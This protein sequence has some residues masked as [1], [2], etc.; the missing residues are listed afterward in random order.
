MAEILSEKQKLVDRLASLT[1]RAQAIFD[2]AES[3][4]RDLTEAEEKT[5]AELSADAGK[6]RARIDGLEN[7]AAADAWLSTPGERKV[8]DSFR[9]AGPDAR[10]PRGSYANL[11]G[12]PTARHEFRDLADFM[13]AA[14]AGN[15]SRLIRNAMT[16]GGGA[17][18]LLPQQYSQQLLD[19]AFESEIVRPRATVLPM[20]TSE[21]ILPAFNYTDRTGAKRAGLAM[22]IVGEGALN[23]A[24][25]ASVTN[26][27]MTA[28]KGAIFVDVSSELESDTPGFPQYLQVAMSSAIAGG[29]DFY[30]VQ[31]GGGGAPL[32]VVNS[33][34]TA[35]VTKESGQAAGTVVEQNL[36]KMAGRLHPACWANSVWLISPSALP[37]LLTLS[38]QAGPAT[39]E[40]TVKLVDDEG[41]MR[42]M[43]RPVIVTDACSAVGTKGDIVLADFTKYVVGLRKD[44]QIER[45]ISSGWKTDTVGF[46]TI[47]RFD[48]AP[49]WPSAV[50]PRAGS[51]TL[52]P[53][54]V[55]ETRS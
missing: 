51:G 48:G 11:F 3:D 18:V 6:L 2:R 45:E 34:A 30:F 54:V 44:I 20:V 5:V 9:P 13:R 15:D 17:G 49:A 32:G 31:G 39:G 26:L 16:E 47:V 4:G 1:D 22:T 42:L 35:V 33:N 25:D 10:A 52:A 23:Y 50:T 14:W 40:R 12:A 27:R 53:F 37:Q 55:T 21:A 46:R 28:K 24:Q 41:I 8:K 38:Q 7:L 19:Q 29:L 36:L 43:T